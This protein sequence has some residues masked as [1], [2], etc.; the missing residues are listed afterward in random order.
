MANYRITIGLPDRYATHRTGLRSM[1][2]MEESRQV[3]LVS[4]GG[5]GETDFYIRKVVGELDMK[6]HGISSHN[7]IF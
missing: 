3:E 5:K 1:A 7:I 2:D 6:F 4:T